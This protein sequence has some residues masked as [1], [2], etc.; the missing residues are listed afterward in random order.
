MEK[1][2][3]EQR[4]K[5]ILV[6][7][8]YWPPSGGSPVLRWLNFVKYLSEGGYEV[9]VYTPSNPT[10]QAFDEQLLA[11]VP[12]DVEVLTTPIREPANL[13]GL[14]N[15]K[16]RTVSTAFISESGRKGF[17]HHLA[18]WIRGNFFIPDARKY[19]VRPSVR[20]LRR[21][22]DQHPCDLIIST[23]PPHSMH[24][25]AR[26]L[27]KR[28]GL[29]WLADFRD[30]WTRIDFYA[31]LHLSAAADAKHKK[32]EKAV[33]DDCDTVIT[34]GPTMTGEF[35]G[36]TSSPV[37]TITNGYDA[38]TMEA[39][40]G[41]PDDRFTLL[42]VGSMPESRNPEEVWKALSTLV[43]TH[44]TFRSDLAIELIGKVDRSVRDSIAEQE[45][46]FALTKSD[47]LPNRDVLERMKSVS[48]LLLVVNDTPNA[49]GILTN[50]FFEYLAAGKPILAVGPA[51]GDLAAILKESGAGK[52]FDYSDTE[53]IQAYLA[54][55]YEQRRNPAFQ[56]NVKNIGKFSRKNLTAE[57]IR[58]I[59][60][61]SR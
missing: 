17:R 23:G 24:L 45:L 27:K 28:T 13:F 54:L 60:E 10:P 8:Y 37:T 16:Q 21:Y 55:L 52:I 1:T 4:R 30:P 18:A 44:E 32:L 50:K 2:L 56:P 49:K 36:M 51:D 3:S 59:E 61:H 53:G 33:L 5:R 14:R 7:T 31:D 11:Q 41:K 25:I 43:N 29:P 46:E 48:V 12:A 47:S 26:G 42:H 57:L 40:T 58:I 15:T 19:W 39:V 6:I 22:L 20:F 34:V 38:R 35:A 9:V